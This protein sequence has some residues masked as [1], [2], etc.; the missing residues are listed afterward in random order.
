[1]EFFS[2][3][4]KSH[5]AEKR[6]VASCRRN[7]K[8]GVSFKMGSVESTLFSSNFFAFFSALATLEPQIYVVVEQFEAENISLLSGRLV[9][10]P[11]I[12]PINFYSLVG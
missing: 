9:L 10:F 4:G 11:I 7:N 2:F 8:L 5:S 1:M 12:A 6:N 3:L